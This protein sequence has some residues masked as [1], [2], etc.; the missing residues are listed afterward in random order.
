MTPAVYEVVE[1]TT[2]QTTVVDVLLGTFAF[3]GVLGL[4]AVLLGL[5][6]A[7]G[8]ILLN[9]DRGDPAS[10]GTGATRLGLDTTNR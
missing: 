4:V 2:E 7:G 10:G 9:K 5:A 8:L 3:V 1:Q 6:M